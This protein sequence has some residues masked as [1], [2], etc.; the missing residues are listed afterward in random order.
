[1]NDADLVA[2]FRREAVIV[3]KAMEG[4]LD[5]VRYVRYVWGRRALCPVCVVG[6]RRWLGCC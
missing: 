2:S 1:M 4:D 3:R 6:W 5:K